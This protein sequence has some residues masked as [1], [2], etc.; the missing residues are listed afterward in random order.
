MPLASIAVPPV[1]GASA[2]RSTCA[3]SVAAGTAGSSSQRVASHP[4]VEVYRPAGSTDPPAGQAFDEAGIDQATE[5]VGPVERAA[6]HRLVEPLGFG[7][8][9]RVRQERPAQRQVV[10]PGPQRGEDRGT[11]GLTAAM[12]GTPYA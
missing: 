9:E 1:V 2:H 7:H 4:A 10:D 11:A 6:E 3:A 5:E 12:A 8:C